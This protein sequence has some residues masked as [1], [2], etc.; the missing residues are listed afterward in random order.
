[1]PGQIARDFST[2][3]V[4]SAAIGLDSASP[5]LDLVTGLVGGWRVNGAVITIEGDSVRS[6]EDGTAP[7]ATV[8]TPL[9]PGD[10][11]TFDCWS[12]GNDWS[13]ALKAIQFIRVTSDATLSIEWFSN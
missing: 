12:R 10:V 4:S 11:L 1:M 6:R 8:G 9:Y 7:T 13:A 5:A 3:T 2:L